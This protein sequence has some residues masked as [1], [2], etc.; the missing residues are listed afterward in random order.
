MLFLK[1]WLQSVCAW[2]DRVGLRK[3]WHLQIAKA[4]LEQV[5]RRIHHRLTAPKLSRDKPSS[6][7]SNNR[8]GAGAGAGAAT[9]A[10]HHKNNGRVAPT[11]H[12]KFA[13]TTPTERT[14]PQPTTSAAAEVAAKLTA[15]SSSAAVFTS[16]LSS[17]AAEEANGGT[18][19]SP[20]L[21]KKRP[22]VEIAPGSDQS[23]FPLPPP[24]LS[25]SAGAPNLPR[26]Q[27]NLPPPPPLQGR[28][29][30][31]MGLPPGGYQ[32]FQGSS[33]P[34]YSEPPLPAPPAPAPRQ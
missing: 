2:K 34:Y 16:V 30:M 1:S 4:Q 19:Q 23:P 25:S 29:M 11:S 6:N 15:N 12:T 33:M 10:D 26:Y 3:A 20:N 13:V 31:G 18:L 17:L 7:G 8:G 9:A 32:P 21:R 14:S 5:G 22:R 28:V 24:Y 27:S